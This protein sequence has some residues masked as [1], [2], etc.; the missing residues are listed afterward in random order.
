MEN[1][2]YEFNLKVLAQEGSDLPDG[3]QGAYVPC[4][5]FADDYQEALKKAVFALAKEHLLL[6]AIQGG[7]REL[8][9]DSWDDYLKSVWPDFLDRFPAKNDL[10]TL[11]KGS[12]VFF[13]PFAVFD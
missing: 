1:K 10:P 6:E 7:V 4:Y 12:A 5:V 13:G 2:L 8:P 9:I 11:S 3:K